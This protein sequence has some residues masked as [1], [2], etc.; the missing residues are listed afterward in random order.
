MS[1]LFFEDLFS[2]PQPSDNETING[3][4]VVRLSE[5]AEVLNGLLTMLYPIPPKMPSSYDK[6]LALLVASQKYDMVGIQSYIRTEIR[7]RDPLTQTGAVAFRAYALSSSGRLHSEMVASARLTLDFPMT[8]EYLCDELPLFEGW[9]LRDLLRFRNRCRDNLISCLESFL[10]LH[11]SSLKVWIPCSRTALS[12]T[13]TGC[14]PTWLSGLFNRLITELRQASTKPL[15][16]PSS[17]H[18]EYLIALQAHLTSYNFCVSCAKVH[19]L[20]G[21]SFRKEIVNRLALA[22]DKVCFSLN[23]YLEAA[24]NF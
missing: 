1:S 16:N 24:H 18:E 9:A 7:S 22:L 23:S 12:T 15:L 11:H 17:F 4:P 10:N 3:L 6:V 2:L 14:L 5:D 21:E 20:K 19:A 8:F 13:T